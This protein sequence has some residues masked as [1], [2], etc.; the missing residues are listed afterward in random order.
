[1]SP[2]RSIRQREYLKWAHPEI[3][4]KWE[5]KYGD[6][7]VPSHHSSGSSKNKNSFG[8]NP[9]KGIKPGIQIKKGK[10]H[11]G[12]SEHRDPLWNQPATVGDFIKP[13]DREKLKKILEKKR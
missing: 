12:F 9:G 5:S 10:W 1:M 11:N 2:F 8:I 3:Y 6:K 7:I 13:Q 4:K